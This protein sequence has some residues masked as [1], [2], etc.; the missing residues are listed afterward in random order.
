MLGRA[1]RGLWTYPR[2]RS[3]SHAWARRRDALPH[4]RDAFIGSTRG[5]VET[6][7]DRG[8]ERPWQLAARVQAPTL[9]VY[10]RKDKLVDPAAAHRATTAFPVAHVMVIPDSGHV[11]QMEHPE[12]VD[13]WWREF[14]GDERG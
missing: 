12:L 9:L 13:R 10:G 8:P 11:A 7:L 3:A 1:G 6:Y 2:P 5:L 4:V 14:L